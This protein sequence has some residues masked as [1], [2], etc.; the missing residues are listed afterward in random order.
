[1]NVVE[2]RAKFVARL[3]LAL[4]VSAGTWLFLILA[5]LT[6]ADSWVSELA[7]SIRAPQ[8]YIVAGW[9]LTL[10][11]APLLA[12]R[13]PFRYRA[14]F[15]GYLVAMLLVIISLFVL[16]MLGTVPAVLD[17]SIPIATALASGL[18]LWAHWSGD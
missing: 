11:L 16:K 14:M 5:G 9:L 12:Y 8:H 2:I 6:A 7:H 17:R 13:D 4:V 10:V 18:V 3:R 1:M 15:N